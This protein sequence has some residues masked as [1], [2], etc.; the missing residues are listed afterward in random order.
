VSNIRGG[1]ICLISALV[2]YELTDEIM[3][4]FWIAVDNDN[5]KAKFPLCRIVRMRDMN[6]GIKEQTI[7]GIKVKIFD[8]ERTI[9]DSFRLLDHETA[10]KA[11]KAYLAREKGKPDLKKLNHYIDRLRA[12]KIKQY[13]TAL[14]A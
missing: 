8:I 13:L 10:I 9:V 6:L 4:E 5:S 3:K 11:L 7:A 2:Y 12:A 1:V 14:I